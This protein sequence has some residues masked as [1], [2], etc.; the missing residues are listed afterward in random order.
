MMI[1]SWIAQCYVHIKLL[2]LLAL[3]CD[4]GVPVVR[5]GPLLLLLC[6]VI[7]YYCSDDLSFWLLLFFCVA[8]LHFAWFAD[9]ALPLAT[10]K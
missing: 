1:D 4:A 5:C 8:A 3:L 7:Y 2:Q 10:K 6:A 9:C